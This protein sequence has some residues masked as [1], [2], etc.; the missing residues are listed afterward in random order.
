[1][2]WGLVIL[3]SISVISIL[4]FFILFIQGYSGSLYIIYS[5]ISLSVSVIGF[6]LTVR[7]II[8][9][10][11]KRRVDMKR[12]KMIKARIVKYF[13]NIFKNIDIVKKTKIDQSESEERIVRYLLANALD[14]TW[15]K[16]L[17]LLILSYFCK[18]FDDSEEIDYEVSKVIQGYSS[19]LKIRKKEEGA[20]SF[21]ELYS[22]MNKGLS[23]ESLDGFVKY[24]VD[25][26][27]P[28]EE[29][30]FLEELEQKGSLISTLR[31]VIKEGKL[32]ALG[33]TETTISQIE[34]EMKEKYVNSGAYVII[35]HN[36]R[37][38]VQEYIE[39]FELYGGKL[40]N[41]GPFAVR[42]IRPS[43][44]DLAFLN[45]LETRY[46]VDQD[47]FF[48]VMPLEIGSAKV[49]KHPKDGN[50]SKKTVKKGYEITKHFTEIQNVM[51]RELVLGA[52]KKTKVKIS[53]LLSVIPFNVLSPSLLPSENDFLISNYSRVKERLQIN[54]L[55]DFMDINPELVAETILDIGVPEY[56]ET[57]KKTLNLISPVD[58]KS[59]SA[60]FKLIS[61]EIVENAT[62]YYQAVDGL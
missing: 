16:R 17:N 52:I 44:S 25:T 48:F 14:Y 45:E 37:G 15:Q 60:R 32:S 56:D 11:E 24:F 33:V 29:L 9:N 7:V 13:H 39:S 49:V 50:F 55:T 62:H 40:Y 3:F 8:V 59:I 51:E 23:F 36:I 6:S 22:E 43:T 4:A 10:F 1:M 21:F 34:K 54:S 41:D 53:Q 31:R 38:T 18:K 27:L 30:S 12:E 42:I 26:Y 2:R 28:E 20:A 47:G 57:E 5:Y 35:G 61:K 58:P 19:L 46:D